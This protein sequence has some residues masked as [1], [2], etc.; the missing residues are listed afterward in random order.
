MCLLSALGRKPSTHDPEE[1][2]ANVGALLLLEGLMAL[3]A[4]H[5]FLKNG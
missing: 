4:L 3:R 2:R 5:Q 1:V